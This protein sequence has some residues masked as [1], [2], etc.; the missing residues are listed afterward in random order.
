LNLRSPEVGDRFIRVG[1]RDVD[2][3]FARGLEP[4]HDAQR[5]ER[6]VV[7]GGRRVQLSDHVPLLGILRRAM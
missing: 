4:A 2:H 7:V 3:L 5:L 1:S 6:E